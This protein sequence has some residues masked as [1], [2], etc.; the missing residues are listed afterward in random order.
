MYEHL[1]NVHFVVFSSTR[2][3]NFLLSLHLT[4]TFMYVSSNGSLESAQAHFI[5]RKCSKYQNDKLSKKGDKDQESIQSNTTPDPGY[6][7]GK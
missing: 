5:A 4:Y 7:M 2:G 1:F 6:R 3:P